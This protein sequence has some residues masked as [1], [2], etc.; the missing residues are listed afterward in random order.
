VLRTFELTLKYVMHRYSADDMHRSASEAIQAEAEFRLQSLGGGGL[1]LPPV[2]TP[3]AS[4][5]T[6]APAAR[7]AVMVGTFAILLSASFASCLV[8]MTT[9][10]QFDREMLQARYC[11]SAVETPYSCPKNIH[12]QK[13]HLSTVFTVRASALKRCPKLTGIECSNSSCRDPTRRCQVSI[14]L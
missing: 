5:A 12:K 2:V 10:F 4:A 7:D 13:G 6:N 9:S 11:D 1:P 8:E 14:S 3:A